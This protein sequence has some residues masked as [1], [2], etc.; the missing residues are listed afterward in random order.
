MDVINIQ[1]HLFCVA[2]LVLTSDLFL[3]SLGI[4]VHHLLSNV[5]YTIYCFI[6]DLKHSIGVAIAELVVLLQLHYEQRFYNC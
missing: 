6:Q 1:Q 3:K 5:A 2:H 4:S